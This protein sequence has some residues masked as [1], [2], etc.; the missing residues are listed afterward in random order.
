MSL[1]NIKAAEL[2]R[3]LRQNAIV[4]VDVRE[5]KEY[6]S[7][8]IAGAV[9]FPLSRFDPQALPDADGKT[10]V[11]Y[12]GIGARSARAVALCQAAGVPVDSH[13]KGGIQG[14]IIAGL[15]V[16]R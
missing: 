13:L 14:W 3:L 8:R 5:P 9:P 1:K 15:P 11:F 2:A 12:C 6:A 4:L 7:H 10:I 16:E